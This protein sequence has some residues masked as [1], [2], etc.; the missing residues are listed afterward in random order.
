MSMSPHRK[1]G[2]WGCVAHEWARTSRVI[3]SLVCA[4]PAA[5]STSLLRLNSIQEDRLTAMP[6][7]MAMNS[8]RVSA[9]ASVPSP[10]RT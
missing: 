5:R 10:P 6:V 8:S 1:R 9:A 2:A 4:L 3:S 7:V